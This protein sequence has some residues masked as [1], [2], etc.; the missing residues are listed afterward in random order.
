MIFTSNQR[1]A[2][3]KKKKSILRGKSRKKPPKNEPQKATRGSRLAYS[4]DAHRSMMISRFH[5]LLLIF[6]TKLL[7]HHQTTTRSYKKAMPWHWEEWQF[8]AF[9]ELK[10]QMC[11]SPMLAQ[12][13]F[14]KQFILQVDASAYGMGAI[15]SQ[16]GDHLTPTLACHSKPTL[17]LI[18][19][20]SATFT[21]TEWNYDIYEWE[22]LAIM[23]ALAHWR[24]Y[25]G[26]TKIPFIIWTDHAN[27]QYWKSPR[28][29]NWQTTW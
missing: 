17:H 6:H 25:L 10:M 4:Q 16:K 1:N 7:H 14:N 20:Y 15:L 23:K 29:L 24:L 27:L 13:N 21:A 22:L 28:N 8:K 3:S 26:W 19:Y 12:L 2:N 5:W 18:A 9:E 11:S